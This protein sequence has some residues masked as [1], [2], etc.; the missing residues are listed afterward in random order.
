MESLKVEF[1]FSGQKIDILCSKKEK[2]KN[3]VEKFCIKVGVDKKSIYCLYGGKMLDENIT[4]ETLIKSKVKNEKTSILVY[5]KENQNEEPKEQVVKSSHIICP[6][7]QDI[8]SIKINK[9]KIS[10]NCK[11]NHIINNVFL[12]DFE[13]TQKIDESKIECNL[14][15]R[16]NKSDSFNKEFF[17]CL[18]CKKNLCPLC[19]SS[20]QKDHNIIKYNKKNFICL[21]HG[22]NFTSYCKACKKNLCIACEVKHSDND[23][24][25]LGKLFPNKKELDKRISELS[26]SI[27]ILKEDIKSI[28]RILNSF[29]KNIDIFY[30][31]NTTINNSFDIK[32]IN[33]ELLNNIKEI[34]YNNTIF[35][36]IKQIINEKS[37]FHKFERIL[38]IHIKMI[39]KEKN[40]NFQHNSNVTNFFKNMN[41]NNNRISYN[42]FSSDL[43]NNNYNPNVNNINNFQRNL[44]NNKNADDLKGNSS[45]NKI[46]PFSNNLRYNVNNNNS[47]NYT[48]PNYNNNANNNYNSYANF[49]SQENLNFMNLQNNNNHSIQNNN[50]NNFEMQ[51]MKIMP[52]IGLNLNPKNKVVFLKEYSLEKQENKN[53]IKIIKI[54][55][56]TSHGYTTDVISKIGITIDNF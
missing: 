34:N 13:R 12:K 40:T 16:M 50:N 51:N 48:N 24:M 53:I 49:K 45:G 14:C 56:E 15:S 47:N 32:S 30:N 29:I 41:I 44:N 25:S 26:E 4:L 20:H 1:F 54:H 6:V 43:H 7:C 22:E 17:I 42:N 19:K 46:R 5:Q 28:I 2:M 27:N 52:I 3:I 38:N 33:Y 36:D 35:D 21:E 9:Y 18:N 37:I 10:F 8:A 55:F 23:T 11:N 39:S 31:I